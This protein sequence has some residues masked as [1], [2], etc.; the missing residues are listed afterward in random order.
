MSE[1]EDGEG[2]GWEGLGAQEGKHKVT[3][4]DTPTPCKDGEIPYKCIQ[5]FKNVG[6]HPNS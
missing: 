4:V 2:G 6:K 1:A 5:S 3:N